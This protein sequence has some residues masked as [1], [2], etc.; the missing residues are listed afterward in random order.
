MPNHFVVYTVSLDD[1]F[2]HC[3]PV[4]MKFM[5][6]DTSVPSVIGPSEY[7]PIPPK[8]MLPTMASTE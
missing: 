1:R 2:L 4:D 3:S 5:V 6:V 8:E 7:S